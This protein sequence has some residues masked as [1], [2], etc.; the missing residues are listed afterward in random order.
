[1]GRGVV[2]TWYLPLWLPLWLPLTERP[3]RSGGLVE[4]RSKAVSATSVRPES[5]GG[6]GT[7]LTA[8]IATERSCEFFADEGLKNL[9]VAPPPSLT[10]LGFLTRA[11]HWPQEA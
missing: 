10:R 11:S 3:I 5:D 2:A 7:A 1:M 6:Y 8:S 4:V 9:G